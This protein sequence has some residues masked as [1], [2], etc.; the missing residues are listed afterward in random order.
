MTL[1]GLL[2]AY[3]QHSQ[4]IFLKIFDDYTGSLACLNKSLELDPENTRVLYTKIQVLGLLGRHTEALECCNLLLSIDYE[5]TDARIIKAGILNMFQKSDEALECINE[6]LVSL[7]K[8]SDALFCKS[9]VLLSLERY[10]EGLACI[11]SALKISSKDPDLLVAKSNAL[12]M[13]HRLKEAFPY[14]EKALKFNPNNVGAFVVQ[15]TIFM[16]LRN[17]KNALS[18]CDRALEIDSKNPEALIMKSKSLNELGRPEEALCA[19]DNVLG[20]YT[21]NINAHMIKI[22]SLQLMNKPIEAL[23]Y[24]RRVLKI[25]YA[26]SATQI[27]YNSDIDNL[28]KIKDSLESTNGTTNINNEYIEYGQKQMPDYISQL[29]HFIDFTKINIPKTEDE[30]HEFKEHYIY[31]DKIGKGKNSKNQRTRDS[32]AYS[33]QAEVAR[34]VAGFANAKGGLLFIGIDDNGVVRGIKNDMEYGGFNSYS[35]GFA[36]HVINY[37]IVV[38]DDTVFVSRKIKIGFKKINT[39]HICIVQVLPADREIFRRIKGITPEFYVRIGPQT[40]KLVGK[41]L[42]DYI[43]KRY[44]K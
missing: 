7:P 38:L 30:V 39:K 16:K 26:D 42:S 31:N 3:F 12:I 4:A 41:D 22:K 18:L 10:E 8:S 35:D 44:P 37:L 32:L 2:R 9:N 33:P 23:N 19:I 28:I 14:A 25:N 21:T 34:T 43:K 17:F 40:L 20:L 27:K 6:V 36:R 15:A 11:D 13:L 1:T 24:I 5:N 29:D